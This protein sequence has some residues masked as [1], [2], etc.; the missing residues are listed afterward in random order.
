MYPTFPF[1][2]RRHKTI[3]STA[4][5]Q[6]HSPATLGDDHLSAQF[7]ELLPQILCFQIAGDAPQ[8]LAVA[9]ALQ[10]RPLGV[11]TVGGGGGGALGAGGIVGVVLGS[12]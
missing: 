8:V 1:V 2:A 5:V 12:V 10:T 6:E 3:T 4:T 7:V 9:G 11:A